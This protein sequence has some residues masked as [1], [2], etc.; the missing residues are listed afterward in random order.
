[1]RLVSNIKAKFFACASPV[2]SRGGV[3]RSRD[4][5]KRQASLTT[6]PLVYTFDGRRDRAKVR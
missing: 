2:I 6:E 3:A 5:Y 4:K 1:M